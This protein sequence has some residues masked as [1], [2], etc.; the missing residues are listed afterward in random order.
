MGKLI[1]HNER[2]QDAAALIKICPFGAMENIGGNIEI[3]SACR[4]CKLCVKR[5]GGVFEIYSG[6]ASWE[7]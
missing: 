5:G 1:V 4:L 7:N 6:R 3:N 2:V